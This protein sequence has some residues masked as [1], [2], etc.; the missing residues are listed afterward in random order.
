MEL[1]SEKGEKKNDLKIAGT[2]RSLMKSKVHEWRGWRTRVL[3]DFRLID[4]VH[5]F[6]K[7]AER[8]MAFSDNYLPIKKLILSANQQVRILQL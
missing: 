6:I 7:I 3:D 4:R 8:K 1:A 5:R 2:A